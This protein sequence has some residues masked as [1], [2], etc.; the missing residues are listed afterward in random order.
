MNSSRLEIVTAHGTPW[1]RDYSG[2]RISAVPSE[3]VP[4]VTCLPAKLSSGISLPS[5]L[6]LRC[7]GRSQGVEHLLP[8]RDADP[9]GCYKAPTDAAVARHAF[10][11]HDGDAQCQAAG[12]SRGAAHTCLGPAMPRGK[13][14]SE[15]MGR[16]RPIKDLRES[17]RRQPAETRHWYSLARY[18]AALGHKPREQTFPAVELRANEPG[19][20]RQVRGGRGFAQKF[21]QAIEVDRI[22]LSASP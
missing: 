15:P 17:E 10:V 1:R 16:R 21:R 13:G 19:A 4:P 11:A 3:P 6:R 5:T 9:A 14:R 8:V 12:R 18:R 7:L 2:R 20:Q 22:S